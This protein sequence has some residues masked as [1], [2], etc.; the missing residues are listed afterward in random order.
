MQNNPRDLIFG[1][2]CI[3]KPFH[4]L[5]VG[6]E[7]CTLKVGTPKCST[8]KIGT[9]KVSTRKVCTPKVCTIKVCTLKVCT[10]KVGTIKVCT[11]KVCM[12][13]L[14]AAALNPQIVVF[15]DSFQFRRFQ[16]FSLSPL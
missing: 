8:L 4:L 3:V 13:A 14:G 12:P 2:G 1:E 10:P 16:G 7:L 5:K 11:R 9:H 15:K 6:G